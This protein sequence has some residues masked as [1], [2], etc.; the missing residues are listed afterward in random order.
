[1]RSFQKTAL[2]YASSA[3][4]LNPQVH[5]IFAALMALGTLARAT[6]NPTEADDYIAEDEAVLNQGSMG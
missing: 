2:E 3:V 4:E 6:S 5:F 1:M